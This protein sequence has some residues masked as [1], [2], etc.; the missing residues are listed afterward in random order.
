MKAIIDTDKLTAIGDAIR[1]KTGKTDKLTASQ[2]ADEIGNMQTGGGSD[3]SGEV[4][5]LNKEFSGTYK[6]PDGAKALTSGCFYG[7]TGLDVLEIPASVK[8]IEKDVLN[9]EAIGRVIIHGTPIINWPAYNGLAG[10][11]ADYKETEIIYDDYRAYLKAGIAWGSG[12]HYYNNPK[13][14]KGFIVPAN[15]KPGAFSYFG[16]GGNLDYIY[17]LRPYQTKAN[18]TALEDQINGNLLRYTTV[19]DVFVEWGKDEYLGKGPWGNSNCTV[20][21][22]TVFNDD[23]TIKE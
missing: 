4:A 13:N 5:L 7:C 23:G 18:S 16:A 3:R 17:I 22:N 20:H 1:A 14:C 6:V 19:K 15:W 2:M 8:T 9:H 12:S 11:D 21:Y 10:G